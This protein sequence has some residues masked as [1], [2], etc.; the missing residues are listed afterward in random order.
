M[1]FKSFLL[2]LLFITHFI[3]SQQTEISEEQKDFIYKMKFDMTKKLFEKPK[4]NFKNQKLDLNKKLIKSNKT[5]KLIIESINFFEKNAKLKII[6]EKTKSINLVSNFPSNFVVENPNIISI[7]LLELKL[8]GNNNTL[9]K[10]LNAESTS[11]GTYIIKSN[12]LSFDSKFDKNLTGEVSYRIKFIT[13]YSS[14]KVS[15]KDIGKTIKLSNDEYKLIDLF[16]NKLILKSNLNENSTINDLEIKCISIN[17][18]GTME[19]F[20]QN[21]PASSLLIK[22]EI[23]H[24]LK[25]NKNF[26]IKVYKNKLPFQE[27]MDNKLSGK[28]IVLELPAPIENEVILYQPIY[29]V[30]KTIKVKL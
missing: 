22:K 27:L 23:Y 28:Y 16:E 9:L 20:S 25:E 30:N 18:K 17:K 13:S 21:S 19:L 5:K 14:I 11:F 26:N 29:G 10:T 8:L 24:L 7:E 3:H 6:N 1:K 2:T 4:Y 12:Q 15:K